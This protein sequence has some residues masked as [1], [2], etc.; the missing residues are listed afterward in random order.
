[1]ATAEEG[2]AQ[3]VSIVGIAGI[4]KSR[5][6]WEFEKHSDGLVR[7]IWWHQ[8][9]CLSYG[10]GV[11]FWALAEMVRVRARITE[12]DSGAEHGRQA[13]GDGGAVRTR[14]RGA[15]LDHPGTRKPAGAR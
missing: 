9:R 4:G 5:L 1:M 13:R 2:R 11:A 7:E 15:R 14:R 12:D 8:G 10:D 3:L 6:A